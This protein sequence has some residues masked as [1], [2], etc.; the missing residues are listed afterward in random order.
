MSITIGVPTF[1][2]AALLRRA[3][4]SLAGEHEGL[5]VIVSDNGSTDNT[6]SVCDDARPAIENF[7]YVFQDPPLSPTENFCF[8]RDAAT[9]EYFGWLADDDWFEPD[10]LAIMEGALR[11]NPEAVLAVPTV[12]YLDA[13]GTAS[14]IEEPRSL[15]D[16]DPQRRASEYFSNVGANGAFYGLRR[17]AATACTPLPASLGG[18]WLHMIGLAMHG[19]F[20]SATGAI[21]NRSDDGMSAD[22]TALA[23]RSGVAARVHADPMLHLPRLLALDLLGGFPPFDEMGWPRRLATTAR[24]VGPRW[25]RTQYF[26]HATRLKQRLRH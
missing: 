9:T 22:L 5:R 1:N 25:A 8:V 23:Q 13:A 12:R 19:T 16:P 18:D 17:R 26:F 10:A 11:A 6:R 14:S 3:L 24:I 20:V 2:R 7:T 4:A 15:T 21:L